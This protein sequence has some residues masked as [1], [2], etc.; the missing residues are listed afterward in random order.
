ML[1]DGISPPLCVGAEFVLNDGISP[2]LY[3]GAEFVFNDGIS[4][5]PCCSL[6]I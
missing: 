2:P 6:V 4:P 5:P 1:N 3:V